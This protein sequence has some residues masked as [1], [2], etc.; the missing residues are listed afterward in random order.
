MNKLK[1]VVLNCLLYMAVF[2]LTA[3]GEKEVSLW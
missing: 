1:K 3:C 2:S